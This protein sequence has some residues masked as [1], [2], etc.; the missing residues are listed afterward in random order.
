MQNH[1]GIILWFRMVW[2]LTLTH[3]YKRLSHLEIST[4]YQYLIGPTTSI[5]TGRLTI[6]VSVMCHM[7]FHV[8]VV[9]IL[10]IILMNILRIVIH[11]PH[12]SYNNHK[13]TSCSH[14]TYQKIKQL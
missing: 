9:T 11:L 1:P 8:I 14:M 4:I 13:D 2:T 7:V 5:P 10:M 6:L 12:T 3:A